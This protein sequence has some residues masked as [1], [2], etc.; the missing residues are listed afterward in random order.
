[1]PKTGKILCFWAKVFFERFLL[2]REE[3]EIITTQKNVPHGTFYI[4]LEIEN[5]KIFLN[6]AFFKTFAHSFI[7]AVVV[8][9]SSK[10]TIFECF[11][12]RT[13]DVFIAKA[14]CIFLILS[15]LS[16]RV[17]VEVFFILLRRLM[18]C[19]LRAGAIS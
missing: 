19:V 8:I 6:P 11:A 14:L 18:V 17:C 3:A 10:I 1:M 4:L 7:V 16:R 5:A 12:G 13:T 9:T 15:F 2:L